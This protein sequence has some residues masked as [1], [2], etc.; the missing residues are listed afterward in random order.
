MPE[1]FLVRHAETDWSGRR[2]CGRTDLPLNARGRT[3]ARALAKRIA[4]ELERG[5]FSGAGP[6]IRVVSSPLRR[7]RET[8]E[9]IRATLGDV[10]LRLDGRWAESD[11]GD[12]EGLTFDELDRAWPDLGARLAA[13]SFDVDWPAGETA[14][15]VAMR[16]TAAYRDVAADD[17]PTIVVSHGG[18]LRLAIALATGRQPHEVLAPEPGQS[19]R[20]SGGATPGPSLSR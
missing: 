20:P 5:P 10:D 6:S 18:P 4:A 9:A 15:A 1:L 16:V 13:G 12:A 11:F 14:A 3:T 17:A 8:A 19:W 2:Y 7:A